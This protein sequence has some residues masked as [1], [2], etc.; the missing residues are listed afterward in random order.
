MHRASVFVLHPA[1]NGLVE[2]AGVII[3]SDSISGTRHL[4]VKVVLLATMGPSRGSSLGLKRYL[5][6]RG[7]CNQQ[8][9]TLTTVRPS[10]QPLYGPRAMRKL[11]PL[12]ASLSAKYLAPVMTLKPWKYHTR[13]R[14]L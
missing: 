11:P 1:V 5:Q 13:F 6:D 9:K 14:R 3:R 10:D 2:A 12:P 8:Q 7:R 4:L